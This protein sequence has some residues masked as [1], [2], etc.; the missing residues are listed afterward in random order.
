MIPYEH[1]WRPSQDIITYNLFFPQSY[2]II[3]PQKNSQMEQV[4]DMHIYNEMSSQDI[5]KKMWNTWGW[6]NDNKLLNSSWAVALRAHLKKCKWWGSSSSDGL[7][8]LKKSPLGE[9]C[10]HAPDGLHTK[11]SSSA[12]C[13]L[14]FDIM[15]WQQ[16]SKDHARVLQRCRHAPLKCSL[17]KSHSDRRLLSSVRLW[18]I[19]N[20]FE[21]EVV[22]LLGIR[23]TEWW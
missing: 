6:I 13:L 9:A 23:G 5:L 22:T 18:G 16:R 1:G 10:K 14:L 7:S 17:T 3:W 21:E 4:Y 20:A 15:T 8:V 2:S 11:E 12:L 19:W